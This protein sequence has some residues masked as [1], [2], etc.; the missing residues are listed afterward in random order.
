M[1]CPSCHSADVARIGPIP[2]DFRFAGR[3]LD[4]LVGGGELVACGRCF[5][6]F[7][8]PQPG[9]DE[10]QELYQSGSLTNWQYEEDSRV[11]WAIARDSLRHRHPQ[12]KVLDVGCFD[13][14]FLKTLGPNMRRFGVEPHPEAAERARTAGVEIIGETADSLGSA[15]ERYFDAVVAF[16][17]IEHVPDP[18]AFVARM[19]TLVREDGDVMIATGDADARSWQMMGARYWYCA[20]PEHLSFLNER[21]V[22]RSAALLGLQVVEIRRYSHVA[23]A[24]TVRRLAEMGTNA[25]CRLVPPLW[26]RLRQFGFGGMDVSLDERLRDYPP[27]WMTATDHMMVILRK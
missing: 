15:H 26:R 9:A 14:A 5:L 23:N 13:G 19:A 16:D 25:L 27:Q 8:W 20:I 18:L 11:D 3:E 17:V 4:H 21:W 12:G 10:L 24:S 1:Q 2:P 6:R 7:R 22:N